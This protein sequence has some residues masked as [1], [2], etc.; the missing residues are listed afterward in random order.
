MKLRK[1]MNKAQRKSQRYYDLDLEYFFEGDDN[2]IT[3]LSAYLA[4]ERRYRWIRRNQRRWRRKQYTQLLEMV[5]ERDKETY[6]I[7]QHS[8]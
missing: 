8:S 7:F 1:D 4:E 5:L 2:D 6:A 3:N